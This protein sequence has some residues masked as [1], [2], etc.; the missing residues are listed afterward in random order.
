MKK[1]ILLLVIVLA[2]AVMP[3]VAQSASEG[4]G[5]ERS[6]I[7]RSPADLYPLHL[8]VSKVYVHAQGYRIIYRKGATDFAEAYIPAPWF[9]PGGKAKLV[10]TRGTEVP[11][12]MVYFNE[13]GSFSHIKLFVHQSLNHESWGQITGDPGDKFSSDTLVLDL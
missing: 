12:A 6:Q 13:D 7:I 11:Y 4:N 2:I 3:L 1:L 5:L 10:P 8:D 9:V